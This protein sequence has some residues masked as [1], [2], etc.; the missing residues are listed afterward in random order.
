V[1]SDLPLKATIVIDAPTA[2]TGQCGET[3][4]GTANCVLVSAGNTI[5]CQLK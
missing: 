4:F 5:K 3:A 2:E 1:Q